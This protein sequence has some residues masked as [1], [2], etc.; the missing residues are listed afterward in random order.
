MVRLRRDCCRF[1][2]DEFSNCHSDVFSWYANL[3]SALWQTL[4]SMMDMEM[5]HLQEIYNNS[6]KRFNMHAYLFSYAFVGYVVKEESLSEIQSHKF[7]REISH[8]NDPTPVDAYRRAS[9]LY[10]LAGTSYIYICYLFPL[11]L[12]SLRLLSLEHPYPRAASSQ[13]VT[14]HAPQIVDFAGRNRRIVCKQIWKFIIFLA[15]KIKRKKVTYGLI[16]TC[17]RLCS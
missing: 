6:R 4:L 7:R 3:N 2:N 1:H 17:L 5:F 10:S 14:F 12:L 9:N 8:W 13:D 11:E 15:F 16:L